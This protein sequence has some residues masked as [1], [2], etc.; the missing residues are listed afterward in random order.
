MTAYTWKL[1]VQFGYSYGYLPVVTGEA[2]AQ[3]FAKRMLDEWCIERE[4]LDED[5]MVVQGDTVTI[6][7]DVLDYLTG[8]VRWITG[9][10]IPKKLHID[11]VD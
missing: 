6:Q 3:A 10:T 5:E 8:A 9:N 4:D 11:R 1:T 7:V 2:E